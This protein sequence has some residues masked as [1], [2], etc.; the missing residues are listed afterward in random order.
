MWKGWK[1]WKGWRGWRQITNKKENGRREEIKKEELRVKEKEKILKIKIKINR[2]KKNY[3]FAQKLSF[4]LIKWR[5]KD[6]M[7]F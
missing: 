6:Y 1:G 4:V 7:C 5:K 3:N 2:I